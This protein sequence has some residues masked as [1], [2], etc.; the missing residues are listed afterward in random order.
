MT[1]FPKNLDGSG[2]WALGFKDL[3]L[4]FEARAHG[5]ED[6]AF[7]CEDSVA[8]IFA[9]V[10]FVECFAGCLLWHAHGRLKDGCEHL[11]FQRLA[12]ES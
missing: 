7:A 10:R 6:G 3:G 11:F 12:G 2:F 4:L 1:G 9:R 8:P 5:V